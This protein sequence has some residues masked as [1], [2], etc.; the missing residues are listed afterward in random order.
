MSKVRVY[1]VAR[2]LNMSNRD[3]VN[4]LQSL[5]VNDVR[6]HMSSVEAEVVERV[7]R[8]LE[9]RVETEVVEQRINKTVVKRRAMG[10]DRRPAAP[11]SSPGADRRSQPSSPEA[12]VPSDRYRGPAPSEAR[13]SRPSRRGDG[14]QPGFSADAFVPEPPALEPRVPEPAPSM[15]AVEPAPARPPTPLPAPEVVEPP[16]PTA[17]GAD[18]PPVEVPPPPRVPV[19]AARD[20]APASQQRPQPARRPT[21]PPVQQQAA[22]PHEDARRRPSTPPKT[23]IEVWEG[24]PGVPMP[25]RPAPRTGPPSARRTTYDPRA[26]AAQT[27]RQPYGYGGRPQPGR[28]GMRPGFRP[29]PGG[30]PQRGG[31]RPEVSTKEMSEHKKVIKI[32]GETSLH[33][34][35]AKMSLK[36]TDVLMKLLSIGMT[37][38]NIN[39][40]LD[41]DTA[42]LL[43]AEFGWTVED[44]SIDVEQE[45]ATAA[46]VE[47]EEVGEA[48]HRPPIVTVM[49]HVDHGKTTLLDTI[50][51]TNVAG[52]EAGGITQHIGAYR[53]ETKRGTICFLDTPG[54]EA[55]TSMRARG[56]GVTDLVILVVAADDGVMPQTKEAIS[57]A[58]S[59]KVPIVVAINKIDKHG[60]DVERIQRELSNEGLVPEDWGGDTM[61][62]KVSAL[63][64]E[65]VDHLLEMVLL[66]SEVLELKANPQKRATGVVVEALLDRGRGPVARVLIQDGTLHRGDVI[67]AGRAYG[68]IR[69]MV[70]EKGRTMREA[71]PSTPVEVLGLTEVPDAGD[72]VHAVKDIKTAETLGEERKKKVRSTLMPDTARVSLE[73]LTTRLAEGEQLELKVIIKS[74]VQGSS[75]ALVHALTKLSTPRVKL[76]VVHTGVGG[77]TETDVNLGVASKAIIIGFN[78]R[79][80]G[81]ARKIAEQEGIEIRLYTIIYEAIDDVK[82]AMEGLLPAKKVEKELGKAQARQIFRIKSIGTIA[83]CMVTEGLIKRTSS[84]RLVRDGVVVWTGKL[85][86]LKRFKD[87]A[88]EVREGFECGMSL[89]GFND[90]KENDVFEAYEIEEIKETL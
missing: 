29:R 54:H 60:S 48:T 71:G 82:G 2:Q 21:P 57:H 5:G 89:D 66:Q 78:V 35:A 34:L 23:G 28:P 22:P 81:N 26:N 25:Q 40:T 20:E 4:L 58:K 69:A 46:Q 43:A 70:D 16:P 3:L 56:A 42:K 13:P 18:A 55:F 9:R 88:R 74:D 45:L 83:G 1:E 62:C 52:G 49:G 61:F 44:V 75:E 10:G 77:I 15:K 24:R 87:D 36:A 59:A 47:T 85:A 7:K 12:A 50:R 11:M 63:T 8:K 79:P 90:V 65:G 73:T 84:I 37:G 33:A 72:P 80:T 76:A 86:S 6:N 41:A 51:K 38:V 53:V 14:S 17:R 19:E 67:L 64:G 68:K 31:R 32:E 39:S 30:P 27:G